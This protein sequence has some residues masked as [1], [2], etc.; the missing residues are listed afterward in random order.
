MS[1]YMFY[2]LLCVVVL[3]TLPGCYIEPGSV[4][5][6]VGVGVGAY[7][8]ESHRRYYPYRDGWYYD[9]PWP[10]RPYPYYGYRYRP[11]PPYYYGG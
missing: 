7:S 4:S 6:S 2:A 8:Y 10:Y 1:I 9:R 11:R 5:T 3:T